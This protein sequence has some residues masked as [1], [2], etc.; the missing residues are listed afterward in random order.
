MM[1]SDKLEKELEE[2]LEEMAIL[3]L[4]RFKKDKQK[5]KDKNMLEKDDADLVNNEFEEV[6][7]DVFH[8]GTLTTSENELND[9]EACHEYL[10]LIV[11]NEE[12]IGCVYEENQIFKTDN[13]RNNQEMC[14]KSISENITDDKEEQRL[15]ESILNE[16]FSLNEEDGDLTV[17]EGFEMD[18]VKS[19]ENETIVALI[20]D[21]ERDE[22]TSFEI[23]KE[24]I[25]DLDM[26]GIGNYVY[27]EYFESLED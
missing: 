5:T 10:S 3:G 25:E 17:F 19:E 6:D 4:E 8:D 18:T 1:V 12:K 11:F 24:D 23:A 27:D 9:D 20:Y 26:N 15:L 14:A 13:T 21:M 16:K 7:S 2:E 22:I